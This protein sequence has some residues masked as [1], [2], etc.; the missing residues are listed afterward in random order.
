MSIFVQMNSIVF[1]LLTGT[2]IIY[3]LLNEILKQF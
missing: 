1:L 3:E 2:Y